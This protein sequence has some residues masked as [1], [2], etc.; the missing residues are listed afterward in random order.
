MGYRGTEGT[1]TPADWPSQR[2]GRPRSYSA[3]PATEPGDG[4]SGTPGGPGASPDHGAGDDEVGYGTGEWD[5][6]H[7]GGAY[8]GDATHSHGA[9]SRG[10]ARGFPPVP[11]QPDPVYPRDDFEAW[12]D[13]TG[14]VGGQALSSQG[15]EVQQGQWGEPTTGDE[16]DSRDAGG[17]WDSRDAGG[18][19][20]GPAAGAPPD[21]PA[22]GVH[23]D[24]APVGHWESTDDQREHG[25]GGEHSEEGGHWDQSDGPSQPWGEGSG[26]WDAPYGQWDENGEW[27][28]PAEHDGDDGSGQEGNG[29]RASG[30]NRADF[31][32]AGRDA[33]QNAGQDAGRDA[34]QDA[35][36]WDSAGYPSYGGYPG[37]YPDEPEAGE[38]EDAGRRDRRR[39]GDQGRK[40]MAGPSADGGP[41]APGRGGGAARK[42]G[43]F[44]T[45]TIVLA[46]AGVV[47]IATLAVVANTLLSGHSGHSSAATGSSPGGLS[48][49]PSPSTSGS[50][51]TS[52]ASRLGK[53]GY[54]TSRATDAAPLT[55]AELYPAQFLITGSSFVR[56]TDRADTNCD[57]ALFGAQLQNAA[58][59]Y[60][61]SQVVRASYISGSQT[62]MGTVGVMNLSG[63]NDAAK[64]GN[65]SGAN[66]FVTPLNGKT[67]LTRNLTQGT[68]VVQAEYK[69]HYLILIWAEF[70]NLKGP[71]TADQ[72]S[73][74]EQFASGLISGSANIA[75]SNRMVSG[76]PEVT[77]SPG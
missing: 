25:E 18:E 15:H 8:D 50:L 55:V 20:D 65:A 48:K 63:A 67:G 57:Q 7:R 66:D 41:S 31:A 29:H 58:K 35:S 11:G 44:R 52:G 51:G 30:Y 24:A 10:P 53:W 69:G 75:L 73:Q 56:T 36:R 3:R 77:G 34:G 32:I 17:E 70:T 21:V 28:S 38:K 46:A 13:S 23:W 40:A 76:H 6:D 39:R 62:M 42:P 33:G 47:V 22:A 68:G 60:G 54:I 19:W 74:L 16:W 71:T 45:R 4:D 43:G 9:A 26:H 59:V 27:H 1:R 72:R 12:G 61:C 49:L 5:A 14:A 2:S 64:A 37:T